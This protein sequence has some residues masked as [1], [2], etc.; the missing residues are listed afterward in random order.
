MKSKYFDASRI[1][2]TAGFVINYVI[3]L[4]IMV[5][6]MSMSGYVCM[7]VI[8]GMSLGQVMCEHYEA[9]RENKTVEMDNDQSLI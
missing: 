7:A 3:K 1:H 2:R 5:L 9:L 8:A 4:F 6:V